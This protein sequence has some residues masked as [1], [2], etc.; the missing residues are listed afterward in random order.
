M[1]SKE[2]VTSYISENILHSELYDNATDSQKSKAINQSLF[3]LNDH[4]KHNEITV[5]DVAEQALFLFKLDS[6]IQRAELG[7]NYV[8]V[9][10]VQLTIQERDR[11]LAPSI[12]KRYGIYST[13]KRRVGRYHVPLSDTNR[14]GN[15]G[16][17]L[18]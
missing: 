18:F 8:M 2:E 11:T 5:R 13:A 17:S 6:T 1:Y 4:V 12:M 9:D 14:Y 7:V 15:G 16:V 3:T 10:G